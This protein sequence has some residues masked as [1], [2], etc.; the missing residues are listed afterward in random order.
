MTPAATIS[1]ALALAIVTNV[2]AMAQ[3]NRTW[4][5]MST[6]SA[7]KQLQ[8]RHAMIYSDFDSCEVG[9]L[10]FKGLTILPSGMTITVPPKCVRVKPSVW[11]DKVTQ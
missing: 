4:L 8:S 7:D 1:A 9:K 11:I 2:A 3:S 6:L 10:M 5:V